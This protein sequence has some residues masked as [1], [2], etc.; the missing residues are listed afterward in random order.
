MTN[1]FD[2]SPTPGAVVP[3]ELP[4]DHPDF[5]P[6]DWGD[7]KPAIELRSPDVRFVTADKL[8][9][10]HAEFSRPLTDKEQAALKQPFGK[11]SSPH[12]T[13]IKHLNQL[14]PG[15]LWTRTEYYTTM[16]YQMIKRDFLGVAD[17]VGIRETAAKDQPPFVLAQLTTRTQ[18]QAHVRKYTSEASSTDEIPTLRKLRAVLGTGSEVVIL[19]Y[20]REMVA[21]ADGKGLKV[22]PWLYVPL[23]V[24]EE[25]LQGSLDRKRRK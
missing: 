8:L 3:A 9:D 2:P 14:Y 6:F 21:T 24:T 1:L 19:G 18:I 23:R 11:S 7:S 12:A 25:V 10:A 13:A 22:S 20:F 4:R 17:V 5:D 16:G 15:Y